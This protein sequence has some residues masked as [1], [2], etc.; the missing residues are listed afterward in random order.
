MLFKDVARCTNSE[1]LQLALPNTPID[2]IN[3]FLIDHHGN[4]DFL[5]QYSNLNLS[6]LKW[7]RAYLTGEELAYVS[8]FPKFSTYFNNCKKKAVDFQLKGWR[9][10]GQPENV[11]QHW[12]EFKTWEASPILIDASLV[13]VQSSK[14]HL[15]EGHTRLAT[16]IGLIAQGLISPSDKHTCW[17]GQVSVTSHSGQ[18][19]D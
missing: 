5:D 2:V 4:S 13:S 6:L 7:D 9:C 15:V 1:V 19:C 14:L 10:I 11:V 16:L 12:K 3:D 17:I 18:P 8:Y